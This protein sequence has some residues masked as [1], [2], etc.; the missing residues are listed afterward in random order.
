MSKL[1]ALFVLMLGCS[2]D[3]VL[4]ITPDSSFIPSLQQ[5]AP[6]NYG[7]H[8]IYVGGVI[9][10]FKLILKNISDQKLINVVVVVT[11]NDPTLFGDFFFSRIYHELFWGGSLFNLSTPARLPNDEQL[12]SFPGFYAEFQGDDLQPNG[13]VKFDSLVLGESGLEL[14]VQAYASLSNGRYALPLDGTWIKW[15]Q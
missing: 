13:Y 2:N 14:Y 4:S 3:H 8:I 9:G 12:T 11:A 7:D 5:A 1:F 10:D 15:T 6:L